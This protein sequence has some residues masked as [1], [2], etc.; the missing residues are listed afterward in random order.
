MLVKER[1]FRPRDHDTDTSVF[2]T[3]GQSD[4]AIWQVGSRTVLP[5]RQIAEMTARIHARADFNAKAPLALGLTLKL[6]EPPPEH[7][8]IGGWPPEKHARMQI[9]LELAARAFLRFPP[10][11]IG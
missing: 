1:A 3:T 5:E 8:L 2:R 6:D 7:V 11:P 4:E 9:A 10:T